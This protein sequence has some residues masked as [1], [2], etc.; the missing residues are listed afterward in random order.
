MS[1]VLDSMPAMRLLI[2]EYDLN[3]STIGPGRTKTAVKQDILKHLSDHSVLKK[4][5]DAY[6]YNLKLKRCLEN[7]GASVSADS[8][9]SI[10]RLCPKQIEL[11]LEDFNCMRGWCESNCVRKKFAKHVLSV[12]R[13]PLREEHTGRLIDSTIVDFPWRLEVFGCTVKEIDNLFRNNNWWSLREKQRTRYFLNHILN[14]E[15][16][17]NKNTCVSKKAVVLF[18]L[19]YEIGEAEAMMQL[20]SMIK[21]GLVVSFDN[22]RFIS[23]CLHYECE[24]QT[25]DFFKTSGEAPLEHAYS[26]AK[27]RIAP[28]DE[29]LYA[30]RS[31]AKYKIIILTGPGGCGKSDVCLREIMHLCS[32]NSLFVTFLGFTHAVRKLLDNV[33]DKSVDDTVHSQTLASLLHEPTSTEAG[34]YI[35]DEASMV[36]SLQMHKLVERANRDGSRLV[37]CG[38]M[39][40]L[41]PIGTGSPFL[42]LVGYCRTQNDP[43]LC[44]LTRVYRAETADLANFANIY[45]HYKISDSIGDFWSL[46]PEN[47]QN[48]QSRYKSVVQTY[49]TNDSDAIVSRFK[50]ACN[51]YK[52][53]GV[54]ENQ[55]LCLAATNHMCELLHNLKREV[56]RGMRGTMKFCQKDQC[57]FKRNTSFFKNGDN[58]VVHRVYTPA[59]LKGNRNYI[60]SYTPDDDEADRLWHEMQKPKET[61]CKSEI[62]F[63]DPEPWEGSDGQWFICVS[64]H[65]LLVGGCVTVHKAQ[66]RGED[67]CIVTATGDTQYMTR[68]DWAY[69]AVSR[70]RKGISLVGNLKVFNQYARPRENSP[71][72]TVFNRLAKGE[73]PQVSPKTQKECNIHKLASQL[74]PDINEESRTQIEAGK[75]RRQKIRKATRD[76]VWRR[77][78]NKTPD[79]QCLMTASCCCCGTVIDKDHFHCA[80]IRSVFD[81]GTDAIEN[82]KLCC[83][84]CNESMGTLNLSAFQTLFAHKEH[85]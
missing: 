38:D 72:D 11:F 76:A 78:C 5:S 77:D 39:D 24:K 53:R 82:L 22:E 43:R 84:T 85:S 15:I 8:L 51:Y 41:R 2:R 47:P 3:I 69:T 1:Y 70:A 48:I 14:K 75:T 45:R 73:E 74:P 40:Q 83:F 32:R 67:Y 80:H 54:E 30:I 4:A 19:D 61:R 55:V 10:K 33:I 13:Y 27:E 18:C 81:G 36:D 63:V 6:N 64:E 31:F 21:E 37:L 12:I 9:K 23:T 58:G 17:K 62:E 56:F 60:V 34:V 65:S 52:R 50:E 49:F 25:L 68:S 46:K 28:S 29:Q 20:S 26:P 71:R 42:D 57:I 16:E 59:R 7:E 79:K 35:L 44:Q 66:G